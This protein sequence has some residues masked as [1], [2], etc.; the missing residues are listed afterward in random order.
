MTSYPDNNFPAFTLAAAQLRRFG[1]QVVSPHEI[2]CNGAAAG[3]ATW[4]DYL[5]S[6]I[7]AM[8]EGAD[9]IATLPEREGFPPSRGRRVEI[10]LAQSL[11]W[12]VRPYT[13]WLQQVWFGELKPGQLLPARVPVP[14]P[15]KD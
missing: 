3:G 4:E 13:E 15:A 9:A 1:Y 5:R 10:A 12:Q 14:V 7:I 2:C 8:M 6:D 11:G